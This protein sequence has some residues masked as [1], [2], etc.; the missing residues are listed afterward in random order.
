M[1]VRRLGFYMPR[2]NYLKV[3]GPLIDHVVRQRGGEYQAVLLL[4][5]WDVSKPEQRVDGA[6]LARAWGSRVTICELP[7]VAA[8]VTLVTGGG[9]DALFS[10]QPALSDIGAADADRLRAA[11]LEQGTKWVAL[12]EGFSQSGYVAT[13]A[14]SLVANWDLVCTV[15]AHS[16]R[17]ID[18]HLERMEPRLAAALRERIAVVGYPE[19]DAL[20]TMDSHSAIRQKYDLPADKPIVVVATAARSV[21]LSVNTWTARGLDARFRGDTPRSLAA[22]VARTVSLRYPT[23]ISYRRYLD[24]VRSF[25]DA[26]GAVVVAK[27]RTKHR[28]HPYVADAA[29]YLIDDRSFL[30]FTTLELLRVASLYFGFY[31]NTVSEAVVSGRYAITAL[32][33]PPR[34]MQSDPAWREYG[35]AMTWGPDG[36]WDVSGVSEVIDGTTAEGSRALDRF[37]R[38][39]LDA[40]RV[41]EARRR[42]VLRDFFNYPCNSSA[43]VLDALAARWSTPG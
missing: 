13:R 33:A 5:R 4:P 23:L 21:P 34:A 10:V 19:F 16:M 27:T 18:R 15:G 6:A 7:T 14:P 32:F 38:A 39:G 12:P 8:L 37:A 24:A 9:L 3:M 29:D 22:V 35:R 43:L 42:E 17:Y 1:P 40:Y 41:D 2:A 26:N 11:S 30:P 28:D 20:D 31:S 25:A 36:L